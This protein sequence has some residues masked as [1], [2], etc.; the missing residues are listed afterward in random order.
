MELIRTDLNIDFFKRKFLFM[1]ISGLLILI[2]VVSLILKGGPDF[3]I[4]FA[5]GL[6]LEVRTKQSTST[7]EVRKALV[8]KGF[9]TALVQNAWEL[10]KASGQDFIVRLDLG[11]GKPEDFSQ[12]VRG[13]L[14]ERFGQG[15]LEIRRVEMVGPKV[16]KELQKKGTWA[17]LL[18]LVAILVYLAWRFEFKYSLGA[19]VALFH[20]VMITLGAF[21]VTGREI[22]LPIV[23]A[24]LT[25]VG[26]SVNDTIVV[27][28]RV[29]ENLRKYRRSSLREVMNRSVNETLSRTILTAGTVFMTD[30]ALFLFGGGVIHD[31]AFALLVG[32]VAGTY[33]TVFIASPVALLWEQKF[34]RRRPMEVKR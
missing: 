25:I 20:D 24:F 1:S 21:S 9:G 18:A 10:G 17:V 13:A 6:L 30:L 16:G 11:E 26:Y 23:A 5:G 12:M 15:G 34:G 32:I 8:E 22:D 29:R 3:G 19:V 2:G 7:G 28:D 31:F 4:D 14:E 27:F 33:S